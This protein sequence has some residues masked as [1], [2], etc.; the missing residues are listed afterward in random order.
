MKIQFK[1]EANVCMLIINAAVYVF[2]TIFIGWFPLI[3]SMIIIYNNNGLVWAILSFVL[4]IILELF[5][6]SIFKTL[7]ILENESKR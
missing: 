3:K 2:F 7:D 1:L 5:A 6:W 4:I